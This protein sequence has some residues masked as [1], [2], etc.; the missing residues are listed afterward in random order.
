MNLRVDLIL[1]SEQRSASLISQKSLIRIVSIV[2]PVVII[3]FMALQVTRLLA[4]KSEEKAVE[5]RWLTTEPLEKKAGELA[6]VRRAND[7]L[8]AE[9]EGWSKSRVR[10]NEQLVALMTVVPTNIQ[11]TELRIGQ[12][13]QVIQDKVPARV[14]AMSLKGMAYG[15]EAESSVKKLEQI[16]SQDASF[17]N[18]IQKVEVPMYGAANTEGAGKDDRVFEIRCSYRERTFE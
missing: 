4:V 10:W 16:F 15:A 5:A 7:A 11:L 12:T 18:V 6:G 13:F 1:E 17:S 9:L 3:V 14:F 2:V 8:L